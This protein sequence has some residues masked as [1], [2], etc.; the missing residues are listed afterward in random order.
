MFKYSVTEVIRS[1]R[2]RN[3][4]VGVKE[5]N[6]KSILFLPQQETHCLYILKT[7]LFMQFGKITQFTIRIVRNICVQSGGKPLNVLSVISGAT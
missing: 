6:E 7:S 2:R 5:K 1:V 3:R 4:P